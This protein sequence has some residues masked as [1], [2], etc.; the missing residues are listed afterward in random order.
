MSS[1]PS[2]I[3]KPAK[4]QDG[5]REKKDSNCKPIGDLNII[6]QGFFYNYDLVKKQI[7]KIEIFHQ[8]TAI[9]KNNLVEF[10]EPEKY[11]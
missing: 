4:K 8:R 7:T 1:I 11:N 2:K 10:L 3:T 5:D 6:K 9:D